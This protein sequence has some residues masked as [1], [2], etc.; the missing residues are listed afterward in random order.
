MDHAQMDAPTETHLHRSRLVHAYRFCQMMVEDTVALGDGGDV[1]VEYTQDVTRG[2]DAFGD[3]FTFPVKVRV[4]TDPEPGMA[5]LIVWDVVTLDD[6]TQDQPLTLEAHEILG[7]Y[8][9]GLETHQEVE[10]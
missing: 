1:V 9:T 3:P 10:L 2:Q 6:E 7:A 8:L 5:H 4:Y